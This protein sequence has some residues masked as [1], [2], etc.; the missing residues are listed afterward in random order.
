MKGTI[1][2]Q[3][4]HKDGSIENRHEHNVVFDIPALTFAKW[5]ES[6][7]AM[8]TGLPTPTTTLTS[9]RFNDFCLSEDTISTTEPQYV[10]PTLIT[11][12]GS[13]TVW[14][15]GPATVT[16]TDKSKVT[17]ATWTVQSPLTLKSIFFR[18]TPETSLMYYTHI[19]FTSKDNI[20]QVNSDINRLS[21]S[22]LNL[23]KFSL[24]NS[25]WNGLA[26][27]SASDIYEPTYVD[28]P[29][30]N[31]NERFVFSWV[32]SGTTYY[33]SSGSAATT[34][35]EIRDKDTNSILRSFPLTQ[36]TGFRTTYSPPSGSSGGSDYSYYCTYVVNTGSKNVFIQPAY[37]GKSLN[38]WQIPDTAT[39]DPIPIAATVLENE[40][41]Y[42][43]NDSRN[44]SSG[45]AKTIGPYISWLPSDVS[46]TTTS[47]KANIVRVNGDF[48]VTKFSGYSSDKPWELYYYSS[49][50]S[51][52]SPSGQRYPYKYHSGKMMFY[53]KYLSYGDYT[54]GAGNDGIYTPVYPN[55]TASNFSTPIVLAEGDVLT[56]SY[57]IEVA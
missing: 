15:K 37:G 23:S 32:T 52:S 49:S 43:S 50:G 14:Y 39:E 8:A 7:L 6:P 45:L 51:G 3:I 31:P 28:Y 35:L 27:S 16:T 38:I 40:C 48:S 9:N 21:P 47:R 33:G 25:G 12:T 53:R 29:L 34:T 13:S 17:S 54:D 36:F 5:S 57:K 10:P 22:I 11:T 30:C 56:V 19:R 2:I 46:S 18:S 55:I 4:K 42:F 24:T 1:D 41:N 20:Y 26:S 44:I